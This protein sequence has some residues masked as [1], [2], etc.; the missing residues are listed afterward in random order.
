MSPGV[1]LAIAAAVAAVVVMTSKKAQT[2]IAST[3]TRVVRRTMSSTR[4]RDLLPLVAKWAK[5]FGAPVSLVMAIIENESHFD[6]NATN[7]TGGDLKRGGA[8]GLAQLTLQTA[9]EL[10]N[11]NQAVAKQYW[12]AW[13]KTGKGLLNPEINVAMACFGIARN[14]KRYQSQ[15]NNWVVAGLAW[16][17]GLGALDKKIATAKASGNWAPILT[18]AYATHILK[19]RDTDSLI[20]EV[21]AQEK[22]QKLFAYA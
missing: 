15:P 3:A 1:L 14:W 17:I 22:S 7:L 5:V 13:D 20:A 16:N 12:P 2:T 6:P 19:N 8:W 10:H 4:G 9:L 21:Y 18:H 11:G